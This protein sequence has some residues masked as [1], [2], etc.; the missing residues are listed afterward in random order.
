MAC[1]IGDGDRCWAKIFLESAAMHRFV[2]ASIGSFGIVGWSSSDSIKIVLLLILGLFGIG[3]TFISWFFSFPVL[4]R[5]GLVMDAMF[6][7]GCVLC[8]A[9][10]DSFVGSALLLSLFVLCIHWTL[11]Y[12]DFFLGPGNA[13]K[14]IGKFEVKIVIGLCC[15]EAVTRL[16]SSTVSEFFHESRSVFIRDDVLL[17]CCCLRF[18]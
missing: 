17:G 7:I 10:L 13:I 16:M 18:A 2:G 11:L 5:M 9:P 4:F 15:G 3:I 1:S 6:I 8:C 14:S 12:M